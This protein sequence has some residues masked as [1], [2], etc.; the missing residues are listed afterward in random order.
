MDLKKLQLYKLP[1]I[2]VLSCAAFY[3]SFAYDLDRTDFFKLAGLYLALFYLSFNLIQ[4]QKHNFWF[5]AGAA[6]VFRL[7]W[8]L[9]LPDLSQDYF[10]FIWDG[11]LIAE[12]MNPFQFTPDQLMQQPNFSLT[13]GGELVAGM[14]S[15]SAGHYSNYPPVSQ[16]IFAITGFLSAGSIL[17]S[18]VVMRIILILADIGTLFIG[19][20]LLKK[21]DLPQ[22]SIFWYILNPFV[23]I[24]L[25]GNLHFEGVMTFFL[26]L[27]LYLLYQKKWLLSAVLMGL[28]ISVKLLPLVL[29]PLL[30]P[31]FREK[32][33]LLKLPVYYLV[34]G[35][36]VMISFLPFY[37]EEV[38]QNFSSSIGLWF[39]KFEWNASIY[40]LVRWFG[41]LDKGYNII[42]SAG[43]ALAI[44]TFLLIMILTFLR[45][46]ENMKQLFTSMLFAV[47]IYLLFSTTVH[48]WY[49]TIPLMLSIFTSF[50]YIII[51]TLVIILSY[52]AYSNPEY[53]ENL[54]LVALEY[55]A[56]AS[57]FMLE[58]FGRKKPFQALLT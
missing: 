48:P 16:L 37:S 38:I 36:V 29:L 11:R 4:M 26:V 58:L 46:A 45:K 12:G 53:Q 21:L 39:D 55:L 30:I 15:L 35:L 5:L 25:T 17:G 6:L 51:W 9:A 24:E 44:C 20:K 23:I 1:I 40:Y 52:V 19:W 8:L 27:A 54:W 50:R 34:A 33:N 28:A 18:V 31:Y 42:E 43:T 49:L 56:V 47:S 41:Y 3:F 22:D 13:Q 14:G 7:M 32:G 10:R 57:Y 2:F